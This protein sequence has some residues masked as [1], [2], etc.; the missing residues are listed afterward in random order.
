MITINDI[1]K[2]PVCQDPSNWI[3]EDWQGEL[4]DLYEL[5]NLDI[6]GKILMGVFFL[7]SEELLAFCDFC[8]AQADAVEGESEA[9]TKCAEH[10][11]SEHIWFKSWYTAKYAADA[12]GTSEARQ[13]QLEYLIQIEQN[14]GG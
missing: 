12:V 2:F 6:D 11:L 1:R 3:S 4:I 14:R 10:Y 5:A 9:K 8:K 7:S 13:A